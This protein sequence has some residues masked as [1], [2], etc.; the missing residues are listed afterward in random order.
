MEPTK[1][2]D[3]VV[4]VEMRDKTEDLPQKGAVA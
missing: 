4:E 3:K 1:L 2:L